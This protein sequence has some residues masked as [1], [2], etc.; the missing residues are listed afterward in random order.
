MKNVYFAGKFSL[1]KDSSLPLS[2]RLKED[3]RAKLLGN[4]EKLVIP[5]KLTILNGKYHYTGPF[6]CEQAS[7]GVYTSTDCNV[8]LEEERK[9]VLGC[10][11]YVAV[12]GEDFSVGTIVE[13]EW[14]LEAQKEIIILYK[15]QKSSYSICS[16]YWFAIADAAAR[17]NAVTI[18]AYD[19]EEE[20]FHLLCEMLI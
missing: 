13:L 6:Y 20:I 16:E 15:K 10:D 12:F 18:R 1:S 9:E 14:A 19:Q 17:G 5:K 11:V 8:V 3:Y 4:P 2:L 7:T